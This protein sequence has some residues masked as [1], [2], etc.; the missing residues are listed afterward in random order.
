M[1][2][3]A[4]LEKRERHRQSHDWST[5][6]AWRLLGWE[7]LGAE[8]DA[9]CTITGRYMGRSALCA[10]HLHAVDRERFPGPCTFSRIPTWPVFQRVVMG[11]V[12]L[13][14]AGERV[15]F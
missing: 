5:A 7:Q 11:H 1:T 14:R 6:L 4:F 10:L 2:K 3:G 13:E 9:S 12:D 15:Q 8:P